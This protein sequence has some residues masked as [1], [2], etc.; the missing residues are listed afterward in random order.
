MADREKLGDIFGVHQKTIESW[1]DGRTEPRFKQLVKVNEIS[2]VS[3]DWVL[4]VPGS[5][6]HHK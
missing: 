1:T 3:L 6:P 4:C 2:K 5:K